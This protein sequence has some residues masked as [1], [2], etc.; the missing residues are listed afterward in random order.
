M[1]E[2]T[3]RNLNKRTYEEDNEEG[4][5]QIRIVGSTDTRKLDT[6]PRQPILVDRGAAIHRNDVASGVNRT[7]TYKFTF[8]HLLSS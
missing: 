1:E 4:T 2:I 5:K 6:K 7:H 8:S 3:R